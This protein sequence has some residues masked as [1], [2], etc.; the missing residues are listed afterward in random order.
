MGLKAFSVLFKA[1]LVTISNALLGTCH[2]RKYNKEAWK[3]RFGHTGQKGFEIWLEIWR[4]IRRE[5]WQEILP[6]FLS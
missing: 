4:E 6:E 3:L 2:C 1:Y 5:I